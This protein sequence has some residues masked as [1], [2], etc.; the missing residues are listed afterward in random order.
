MTED[1]KDIKENPEDVT[2]AIGEFARR[3][4]PIGTS[5]V[6]LEAGSP[7]QIVM[8]A[9]NKGYDTDFIE[10]ML[11]MQ[12]RYEANEARKAYNEAMAKFKADPPEIEK[13]RHVRFDTKG[14]KASYRHASLANVT[15][16]INKALGLNGLS[17]SWHTEQ[18]NGDI[19][20]TCTISHWLGHS[21]STSLTAGPDTSG[22][23]NAIQAIGSTISYLE[24]YTLL[25]LAGLA[26]ADM[27]DDGQGGG[28]EIEYIS[29]DQATEIND[30]IKETGADEKKFL[31]LIEKQ[32]KQQVD[33]VEA[34]PA[35]LYKSAVGALKAKKAKAAKNASN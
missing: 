35:A 14:G 32:A 17:A 21:E 2:R 10:K 15:G 9:I 33:N 29:V 30:L 8:A 22:S 6:Q 24:R 7:S 12:E 28:E 19:K 18:L 20:V 26:T 31:V 27:D 5:P 4:P 3:G 34:I 11:Q 13:D 23:K 1:K 25:A 16:K